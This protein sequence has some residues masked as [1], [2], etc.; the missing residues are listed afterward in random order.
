M[1]INNKTFLEGLR[2]AEYSCGERC[3]S[4]VD[5]LQLP[6]SVKSKFKTFLDDSGFRTCDKHFI[7]SENGIEYDIRVNRFID[8]RI[9][10]IL[11][12]QAKTIP[13]KS[14][15]KD[16]KKNKQYTYKELDS[17]TNRL[18]RGLYKAGVRVHSYVSVVIPTS[19][20]NYI[21]K[22]A[23]SKLGGV[24]VNINFMER[25]NA[26]IGFVERSSSDTLIMRPGSK[27]TNPTELLDAILELCPELDINQDP[28]NLRLAKLPNLKRIILCDTDL[29]VPGF[30]NIQDLYDEDASALVEVTDKSEED[31]ASIIH[32]SGTTSI[33]KGAMLT[34]RSI[35][36]VL[37]V[38][39]D[40]IGIDNN[41]VTAISLPLF[42]A[43]GSIGASLPTFTCGGT[44]V[45]MDRPSIEE[46]CKMLQEE[47]VT[48][49]CNVPSIYQQLLQLVH[50]TGIDKNSFC[51][52]KCVAAGAA[53][54][55]AMLMDVSE[56]FGVDDVI[57][58]YGMTETTTGI[59]G[60]LHDDTIEQ[61][62][63][64]VGA[65]WP[66]IEVRFRD[67][68]TSE[69]VEEGV[70]GEIEVRGFNVMKGY[71]NEP[72]ETEHVLS[73]DGWLRTGDLCVMRQDHH[74]QFICR[75]KESIKKHGETISPLEVENVLQRDNRFLKSAIVGVPDEIAGEELAAF[76][77]LP[78][79]TSAT[80]E[81]VKA[82]C[83]TEL[84]RFKIP[85]YVFFVSE[86][87]SSATGKIQK[88]KLKEMAIK[89]IHEG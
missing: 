60:S 15:L 80:V 87:P 3:V 44:V 84:S 10:D 36:E 67:P 1:E 27:R 42:H 32:T 72:E 17:I 22:F 53:S 26:V 9:E 6:E 74:I 21:S 2:V 25:A 48:V 79:G 7:A 49:L 47:H 41:D 40:M 88:N 58:T 70:P 73:R 71:L 68:E 5:D 18:A 78:V 52:K 31:V 39:A 81:D 11:E 65:P 45:C 69:L 56:T 66:E 16:C 55:E 46:I 77:S 20:T 28:F 12:H 59:T 57:A 23:V 64:T 14:A 24:I 89:L 13:D 82:Q 63:N 54:T 35:M 51:L 37:T 29:R 4:S 50:S 85:K 33:P 8:A 86:F 34:H 76:V 38:Q 43:F 62:T 83:A 75:L 61:R 30:L 19:D